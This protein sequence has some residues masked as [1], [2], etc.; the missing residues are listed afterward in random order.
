MRRGKGGKGGVRLGE[1][2]G[3]VDGG[4]Q[5]DWQGKAWCFGGRVRRRLAGVS[6]VGWLMIYA[7]TLHSLSLSTTHKVI[8]GKRLLPTNHHSN[9]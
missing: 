8:D 4:L 1:G 7:C 6:L 2:L 9:S 5:G 3:L